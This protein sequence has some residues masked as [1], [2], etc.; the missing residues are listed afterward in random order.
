VKVYL[1]LFQMN[2][3][4]E[5]NHK[6]VN[7]SNF[8]DK[9]KYFIFDY[10]GVVVDSVHIKTEAFVNLYKKYDKNIQSKIANFH[11]KNGGINRREKIKYFHKNYIK[12]KI[13][14]EELEILSNQFSKFVHN[15]IIK[16]HEVEGIYKFLNFYI[17]TKKLFV[18]SATPESE[19]VK[20]IKQRGEDVFFKHI[21]GSPKSKFENL[22]Q[23]IEMQNAIK[24]E[25]I[26]FGDAKQDLEASI[27]SGI[28]FIYIKK[29]KI[30]LPKA[31]IKI[32]F[33][34]NFDIFK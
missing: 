11:I 9:K 26:F 1:K 31:K 27:R 25:F 5:L 16:A 18:N 4:R 7:I 24:S 14:D 30:R 17:K 23:I 34:K 10:D 29:N 3:L 8:L 32:F 20:I 19:L 6:F 12:K 2:T 28:D 22:T 13:N 33:L 15:K 21:Y